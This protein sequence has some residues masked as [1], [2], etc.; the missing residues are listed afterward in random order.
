M[1]EATQQTNTQAP[2]P[3]ARTQAQVKA[4][5]VEKIFG[6]PPAQKT[7]PESDS[8]DTGIDEQTS[9]EGQDEGVEAQ[10]DAA[11]QDSE[12]EEVEFEDF[13][14]Q[15]PKTHAQKVRE[16]LMRNA[17]YTQK[18]KVTAERERAVSARESAFQAQ[19]Q[20]HQQ[21]L[22]D[23]AAI[24]GLDNQL[25]QFKNV[26]WSQLGTEDLMRTKLY[27]DQ[28]KETRQKAVEALQQKGQQ[29]QQQLAETLK[30]L[31]ASSYQ[32]VTLK[33]P[34]FNEKAK[35]ELKR[36]AVEQGYTDSEAS[37]MFLRPSDVQMIWK[38][39]Q[40]DALQASKPNIEKRANGA[41]PV[42]KPG[43]TKPVAPK[44]AQLQNAF[45][46]ETDPRRKVEIGRR[47]LGSKLG[48]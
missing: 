48:I 19:A 7:A 26:N 10:S 13:K 24:K 12:T 39:K 34:G 6:L 3:E 16:A 31:E 5:A 37:K 45:K 42:V 2:Q 8:P 22:D 18:T 32:E 9:L 4:R 38:A 25:D 46:R 29:F 44:N 17:D 21:A 23:L 35:D 41:P 14:L 33:I 20:F 11:P 30:K 28:L 15:L 47:L 43:A 1:A 40:Y 36:Y 27:H